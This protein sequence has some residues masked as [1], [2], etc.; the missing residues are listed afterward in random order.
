MPE[1]VEVSKEFLTV[2]CLCNIS[3]SD[4]DVVLKRK[5]L[6]QCQLKEAKAAF[7]TSKYQYD[8]PHREIMVLEISD[9]KFYVNRYVPYI[10]KICTLYVIGKFKKIS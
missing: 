5:Q 1:F 8:C 9:T 6:C 3:Q 4:G 2:L 7:N 10:F